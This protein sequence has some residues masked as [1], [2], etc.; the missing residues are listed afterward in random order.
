MSW[1][2][3]DKELAARGDALEDKGWIPIPVYLH[4]ESPIVLC[5]DWRD[6]LRPGV[7][8]RL[9]TWQAEA[10]Q[11]ERDGVVSEIMDA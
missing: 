6:P 2:L 3:E 11:K 10:I 7:Q 4:K 9:T 1:T 8:T 5:R